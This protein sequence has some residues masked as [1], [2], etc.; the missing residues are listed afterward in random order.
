[1]KART[2]HWCVLIAAAMLV[3]VTPIPGHACSCVDEPCSTGWKHGQV[4]FLGEV[5][6]KE[7]IPPGR[8]ATA[9][10]LFARVAVHFS[11]REL[12]DGGVASEKD[13]VVLTGSGGGDCGYPFKVGQSYLVYATPNQGPLVTSICSPTRP[14]V[15]AGAF[16][17]QLRLRSKAAEPAA[18]FGVIGIA[19]RG[20]G[21]EDLIESKTLS[22]VKVSAVDSAGRVY[23]ATSG[24]QGVYL[25]NSLP[26]GTYRLE[27]DLPAG[28]ST[29]QKDSGQPI[30]IPVGNDQNLRGCA[31]DVLARAD[32][33]IS[34]V[35]INTDGKAVAG[36]LTIIS[37]D[38]KESEASRQRGGLQGF[39]TED[40][41]FLLTQ[42]PPG[43]YQLMFY[44]KVNG[45]ISLRGGAV[46]SEPI[47][48]GFG[49]HIENFEFK[50][51]N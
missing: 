35:V 13:T 3:L 27:I 48:I 11:V 30:V 7:A 10:R 26:A 20:N 4:V 23:S 44:P 22:G 14:A 34:G 1:M 37:A 18:L 41:K 9:D 40:G 29:W 32:G 5:T 25:L 24:E 36:F 6:A 8:D 33:R 51:K 15:I 2:V 38:P 46:R 43:R 31:V 17:Q 12:F 47:D 39:S 28:L 49:Q 16:I 21:Y 50:L 45:Q 19:P 42:I